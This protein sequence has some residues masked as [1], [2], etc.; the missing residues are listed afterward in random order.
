[1]NINRTVLTGFAVGLLA[2]L[3]LMQNVSANGVSRGALLA[4]MCN[5]CHGTDGAGA[6]PSPRIAGKSVA[7]FMDIMQAFASGEEP[8]TIMDRH[9]Q[10]YT[11]EELRAL[12]EYFS[13]R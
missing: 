5:T 9:A 4:S 2:S 13:Q 6:E 8:T 3:S 7:D 12:A 11:E 1:M 10:G